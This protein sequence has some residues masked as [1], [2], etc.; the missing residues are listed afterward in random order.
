MGIG[1]PI[2]DGVVYKGSKT[3][4]VDVENYR[5]DTTCIGVVTI[6]N[7]IETKLYYKE[8]VPSVGIVLLVACHV[9]GTVDAGTGRWWLNQDSR[10]VR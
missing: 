6:A 1:Y 3:F 5:S 7:W 8:A 2:I 4:S 10:I 9:Y